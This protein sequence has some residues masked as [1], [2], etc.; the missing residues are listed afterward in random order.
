MWELIIWLVI[1]P[2]QLSSSFSASQLSCSCLADYHAFN[3]SIQPI[4]IEHLICTR[5][6]HCSLKTDSK[7]FKC[8]LFVIIIF[9]CEKQNKLL[10]LV[11]KS[12]INKKE[13]DGSY[14]RNGLIKITLVPYS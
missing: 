7:N 13:S 3:S 4:F 2:S 10:V 14:F 5:H 9:K 1:E 8:I 11:I 6:C 12:K